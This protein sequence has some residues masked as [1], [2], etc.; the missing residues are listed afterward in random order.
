MMMRLLLMMF[1]IEINVVDINKVN[2]INDVI[3]VNDIN[4]DV[5]CY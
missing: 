4:K 1:V 5:V 2:V 3:T